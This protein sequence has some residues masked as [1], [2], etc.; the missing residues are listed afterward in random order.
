MQH[1]DKNEGLVSVQ[2]VETISLA[3]ENGVI[4]SVDSPSTVF[5]SALVNIEMN[6]LLRKALMTSNNIFTWLH[7][8]CV[9]AT[10]MS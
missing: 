9:K 3:T 8:S 7:S 1:K 4:R 2:S 10:K 6:P 5:L